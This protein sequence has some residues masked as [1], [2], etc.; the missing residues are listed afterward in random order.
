MQDWKLKGMDA[1]FLLAKHAKLT[2]YTRYD[3]VMT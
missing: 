1:D 3:L 2:K